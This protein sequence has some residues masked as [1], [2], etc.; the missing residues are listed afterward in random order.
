VNKAAAR[1]VTVIAARHVVAVFVLLAYTISLGS[2]VLAPGDA[3][4]PDRTRRRSRI[5]ERRAR[6]ELAGDQTP[7]ERELRS[8]GA[9]ARTR[10][11]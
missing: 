10:E 11:P 6:R 9:V 7:R 5:T 1:A 3:C 4:A 8:R 2:Y